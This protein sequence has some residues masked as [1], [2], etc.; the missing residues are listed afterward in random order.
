MDVLTEKERAEKENR[1]LFERLNSE[2]ARLT[3][4]LSK[5]KKEEVQ[6]ETIGMLTIKSLVLYILSCCFRDQCRGNM[7]REKIMLTFS[8]T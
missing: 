8:V 4:A 2:N 7:S 3:E 1:E 5:V 6:R